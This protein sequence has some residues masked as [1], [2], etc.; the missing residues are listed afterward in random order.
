[1]DRRDHEEGYLLNANGF[2]VIDLG[3]DIYTQGKP[4]PMIDPDTRI[5]FFQKAAQDESTAIIL[6]D[7]VLGYGSHEDMAEALIP[8]IEKIQ[9]ETQANGKNIYFV[10]TVCGTDQDPQDIDEQKAKLE[11]AGVILRDSNNQAI[12]TALAML[13]I[14]IEEVQKE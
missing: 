9:K 10:A 4:H 12:L 5:Q 13:D 8:G 7:V 14:Q 6:F 1:M 3:D 11:K 2:E